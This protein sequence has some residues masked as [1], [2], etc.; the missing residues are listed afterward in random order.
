V[1]K[2]ITIDNFSSTVMGL[3]ETG[4]KKEADALIKSFSKE[5]KEF[6]A[7]LNEVQKAMKERHPLK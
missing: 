6:L 7:L 4:K 1:E 5:H 3:I 2:G